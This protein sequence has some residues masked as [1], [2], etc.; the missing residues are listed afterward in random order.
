MTYAVGHPFELDLEPAPRPERVMVV[1]PQGHG[2]NITAALEQTVFRGDT[3]AIA[4]RLP[5]VPVRGD[6]VIAL[7]SA[8]ERDDAA[9]TLYREYVKVVV[10]RGLQEGWD[11]RTG[12][13]LELV[14]LTRPY[15]LKPGMVF[16]GRVLRGNV[17]VADAEVYFERL[18][19]SRPAAAAHLP[20]P[21]VTFAVRTDSDGRFVVALPEAGWWVVGTYVDDLGTVRHAGRDY[22][23]EGFAGLWLKVEPR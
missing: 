3:N 15:G 7:D 1:D 23:H 8:P 2:T 10:H 11:R 6:S 9:R 4:W 16:S 14:P 12:Q 21:L 17:P 5:F 19:D 22:R 20:E 18:S 13:P